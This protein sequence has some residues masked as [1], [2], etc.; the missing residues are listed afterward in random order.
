MTLLDYAYM[1]LQCCN[2]QN[3]AWYVP[4]R[5]ASRTRRLRQVVLVFS[6]RSWSLPVEVVLGLGERVVSGGIRRPSR[7]VSLLAL[8]PHGQPASPSV[9]GVSALAARLDVFYLPMLRVRSVRLGPSVDRASSSTVCVFEN[10]SRV[11]R[12]VLGRSPYSQ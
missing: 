9:D 12:R 6:Y 11:Q 7:G 2:R 3:F 1:Y 10:F 5:L 4:L 8:T